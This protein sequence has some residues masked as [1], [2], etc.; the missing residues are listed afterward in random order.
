MKNEIEIQ[1]FNLEKKRVDDRKVR[2]QID[3]VGVFPS[4]TCG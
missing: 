2:H 4:L 1:K 3:R